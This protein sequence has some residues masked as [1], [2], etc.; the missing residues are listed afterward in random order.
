M[1]LNGVTIADTRAISAVAGLLANVFFYCGIILSVCQ[2]CRIH[3][4]EAAT[5]IGLLPFYH[6]A[7]QSPQ[8]C[9]KILAV[10]FAAGP[11]K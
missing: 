7:F 5:C 9:N 3:C 4:I 1:T 8:S 10:T 11:L 2:L 6:L